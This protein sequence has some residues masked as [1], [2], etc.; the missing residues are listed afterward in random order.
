MG[1]RVH[2]ADRGFDRMQ[3]NAKTDLDSAVSGISS[4]ITGV[5]TKTAAMTINHSF[6]KKPTDA[7]VSCNSDFV[8]MKVI[9]LDRDTITVEFDTADVTVN[10]RLV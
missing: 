3:R 2:K 1:E 6:G 4:T 7:F 5:V 8:Q 10:I 9:R